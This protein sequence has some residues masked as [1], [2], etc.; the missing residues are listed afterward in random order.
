[1]CLSSHGEMDGSMGVGT[2]KRD[3]FFPPSGTAM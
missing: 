1:M 2:G 3:F